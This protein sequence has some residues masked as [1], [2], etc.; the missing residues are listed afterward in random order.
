MVEDV[1]PPPE[2]VVVLLP[3]V[4]EEP[5]PQPA[6]RQMI[7]NAQSKKRGRTLGCIGLLLVK[8]Q[9]IFNS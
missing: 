8:G 1:E 4:D 5:P 2:L 3:P 6:V 7:V 9:R